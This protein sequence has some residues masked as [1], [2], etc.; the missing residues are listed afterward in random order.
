MFVNIQTYIFVHTLVSYV[1]KYKAQYIKTL[2]LFLV[3]FNCACFV[4]SILS[5]IFC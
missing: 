1:Y 3:K 4:D 5:K 2:K